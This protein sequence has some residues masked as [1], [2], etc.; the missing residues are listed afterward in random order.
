MSIADSG[1]TREQQAV[2]ALD[3]GV[4]EALEKKFQV[5]VYRADGRLSRVSKLDELKASP[6]APATRIGDDLK[7][8]ASEAADLPIGAVV[9]LSDGADNSGGIDL[10]TISTFRSRRIP[11]H[12]VGFGLEQTAHDVEIND[13]VV[14][15][16]ALAD[17]RLAAKV[18]LHQRGYAGQK[19]MLTVRDGGKVPAGRQ[20][21]L[22]ATGAS[23]NE[24]RVFNTGDAV[25]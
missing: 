6:P 3:S 18:T 15:P 19:A 7:E 13:A 20:I 14:A 22:A 2:K 12:T 11:V 16:R 8:L 1:A 5:R 24:P 4:R 17:S 9:L 25:A 23:Q 21:P 10:D